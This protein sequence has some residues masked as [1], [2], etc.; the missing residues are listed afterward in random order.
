MKSKSVKNS[1]TLM[2]LMI[3]LVSVMV[4]GGISISNISTMTSTANKNYENARL[5]GYN[6]EI[7]SQVQSVIAILQA[8]YDKSQNGILTE[9]EAKKEAAEIVRNMRYR[10]DGSGYFWIDD[11]DYNL[12]MH[13]ILADQEGNNRYDLT[14]QNGIKIIQEIMKVSTG[15]DGGGFNEFYFT[16]AD[17]VTVAPKIAYS[18]IFTPWNWV[19]STGNYVDDMEAEMNSSKN[20]V[21]AKYYTMITVIIIIDLAFAVVVFIASRIF[22]NTI[23][24]P[25]IEIQNFANR[26]S[27]GDLTTGVNVS[28]NNEL[29]KT[30]GALDLAQQE[31]VGLISN[32]DGVSSH[33]QSAVADFKKNFD[34]MNES[35][36][37][38]SAAINEIA[39]NSNSQAASTSS[40]SENIAEIADG[41]ADTS[42]EME[43]LDQNA[44]L[45][46][47]RSNKSM[48]TLH[49]LIDVNSTTK[50]DI[51]SMY[52]QTAQTNDSVNKISQAATLISEIASQTNLL[53]LNASIEAARAGEA[54]RGF[55]VVAE[56]IGG[57]ATQSA[58]TVSEINNIISELSQNSEKSMELMK[59]MS[60]ASD[61][62]VAALESTQQMF[63]DLKGALDSCMASIQTITGKIQNVNS[64]RELVT[65]S[66]DTL[67]Q[68]A[69]DNAS[70][71]EETS[72]YSIGFFNCPE[73]YDPDYVPFAI[74]LMYLDDIFF[75]QVREKAGAVYSIGTGV[76][77]GKQMLGAISAY[78]ISDTE[79]IHS[80]IY[81][82]IESFPDE[83]QVEEK[84]EQYKNK[85]ITTLFDSSQSGTGVAAN[86]I[87]SLEY[88][89]KPDTYLK[90]SF[91]VQNVSARQVYSAY[92][93]Y[94]APESKNKI[95]WITVTK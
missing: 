89:G 18:Q 53:S 86:I 78:K 39:Q 61:E 38:V 91:Q 59:K 88:S 13:P 43:S 75:D 66:I 34:S 79:N 14:D 22:G 8:E 32:I 2:C 37:N 54:G 57:L 67:T 12:V 23:C 83:K 72:G 71:T 1:L 16:K 25:L 55:A 74:S 51:D 65:E 95:R 15:S 29:G 82:A 64:Q 24:R 48:E 31:V 44:Q 40:A 10:D 5:D 52:N 27:T 26:M 9:D 70:S 80:L 94:I 62:Q 17:G 60:E 69:T 90:R 33:L 58:Q 84:L 50:T 81:K 20:E 49:R 63:E 35:I 45:M 3:V 30:A 47:D 46:Q 77:G 92:K 87:T 21:Q 19:V 28:S 76:L 4:I 56:E 68:L 85:Y 73:R 11:T 41:I 36:Q 7:K 93:K 6:T 42:S